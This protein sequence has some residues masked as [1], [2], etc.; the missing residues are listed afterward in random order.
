MDNSF[1]RQA[2]DAQQKS[3][4]LASLQI[5]ESI[6]PLM[7]RS[8]NWLAGLIKLTEEEQEDAGVYLG[9]LGDE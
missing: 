7:R 8:V 1:H 9:R 5:F 4:S 2:S 3:G 6:L